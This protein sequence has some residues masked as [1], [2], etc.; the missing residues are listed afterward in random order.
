[1]GQRSEDPQRREDPWNV[2]ERTSLWY[3]W[4][5]GKEPKC[6]VIW[7]RQYKQ[8]LS[9][10]LR[11]QESAIVHREIEAQDGDEDPSS[12]LSADDRDYEIEIKT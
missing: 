8:Y 10:I 3:P 7:N 9:D 4:I 5:P 2:W 1:M 6:D 11:A 12:N